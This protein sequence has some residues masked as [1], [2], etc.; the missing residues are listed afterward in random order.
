MEND[1]KSKDAVREFWPRMG[2]VFVFSAISFPFLS[3]FCVVLSSHKRH[4]YAQFGMKE[5]IFGREIWCLRPMFGRFRPKWA[6]GFIFSFVAFL[7][8]SKFCVG[9]SWYKINIHTKL[10]MKKS[11]FSRVICCFISDP[12][13]EDFFQK[14]PFSFSPP[15]RFGYSNQV[16]RVTLQ[17]WCGLN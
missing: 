17:T 14:W 3:K 9:I 12:F 8:L 10:G 4:F 6:F 5:D 2:I 1:A 7:F 15:F 16:W 13:L 11:R